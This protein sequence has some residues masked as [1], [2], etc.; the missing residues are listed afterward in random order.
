MSSV[1][2]HVHFYYHL[3][4]LDIYKDTLRLHIFF[5][6]ERKQVTNL[7]TDT[8]EHALYVL[9]KALVTLSM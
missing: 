3:D 9:A 1:C 4:L 6:K 2:Y 8:K 7:K 5:L